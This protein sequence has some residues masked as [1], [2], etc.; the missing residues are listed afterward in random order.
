MGAHWCYRCHWLKPAAKL[1]GLD[2]CWILPRHITVYPLAHILGICWLQLFWHIYK[3]K[4]ISSF[5][6]LSSLASNKPD[7]SNW[8][9]PWQMV[10]AESL[11]TQSHRRFSQNHQIMESVNDVGETYT[12][13]SNSHCLSSLRLPELHL[14]QVPDQFAQLLPLL[15][16]VK[17]ARNSRGACCYVSRLDKKV[18]C[19]WLQRT[20]MHINHH[21]NISLQWN[22][23]S[24]SWFCTLQMLKRVLLCLSLLPGASA[25]NWQNNLTLSN[26][27]DK[28]LR[29]HDLT[30][31]PALC[32]SSWASKFPTCWA[33]WASGSF[34]A[35][36]ANGLVALTTLVATCTAGCR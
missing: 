2:G 3:A 15:M 16:P 28:C 20:V 27:W 36:D 25:T 8:T 21:K 26:V 29:V 32:L 33:V 31:C 22:C 13:S 24:H 35:C 23:Q 6:V 12:A 4:W 5:E 18:Q 11:W 10:F 30:C 14:C 34:K 1:A 9:N 19:H 7:A 17:S